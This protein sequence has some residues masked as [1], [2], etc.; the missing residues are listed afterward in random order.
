MYSKKKKILIIFSTCFAVIALVLGLTFGFMDFSSNSPEEATPPSFGATSP[1]V[2]TSGY[3]TDSGRY[4]TTAWSGSGSESDPYLIQSAQDLARLSYMVYSGSGSV[5]NTYYYYQ[6]KYFKQTAN[7]DLSAY[8][9]Q[10]IGCVY[11]QGTTTLNQ[12]YFSGNYDGGG[13]TVSGIFTKAG[14]T[15][16]YSYQ[17]LFGYIFGRSTSNPL[18]IKN[19]GVVNSYIQGHDYIGGIAG[20]I[21]T[22]KISNC[23]N[24]SNV[25]GASIIG[26]IV[27]TY[28]YSTITNCYNTGAL[29]A[30]F[31][32][33]GGMAGCSLHLVPGVTNTITN[34]Y[35]TGAI[36]A[37][38]N[39]YIGGIVGEECII[40]NCYYGGNCTLS[41]GAGNST[42]GTNTGTTKYTN[43]NSTSYAKNKSW[44]TNS[45]NWNDSYPW[46]FRFTW[47]I[48]SN[49]NS[50]YP[51]L[52]SSS[53]LTINLNGGSASYEGTNL[54][55]KIENEGSSSSLITSGGIR[56]YISNQNIYVS[57]NSNDD[58]DHYGHFTYINAYLVK[59]VNCNLSLKAVSRTSSVL[60][61]TVEAG[62]FLN[63]NYDTF[64]INFGPTVNSTSTPVTFSFDFTPTVSGV[65]NLR[66]D[67]N[68][69]NASFRIYDVKVKQQASNDYYG[70]AGQQI[71][72][73]NP[74]RTGYTFKGWSL[75]GGGSISNGVYTFGNLNETL[76]A[77]WEALDTE[78]PV[79]HRA[80]YVTREDGYD[81]YAYATDNIGV[82][83]MLFPTWTEYN[84]QDDLIWGQGIKGTYSVEGQTYNYKYAVNMSDHN[85]EIGVY[86][87]DIYAYD[88]AENEDKKSYSIYFARPWTDFAATSY[89]GGNGTESSPY[90]IATAQQLALL[91]KQ[92][93][94]ESLEGKY[95][96]QTAPIDLENKATKNSKYVWYIWEGIGTQA[97]P[98]QGHYDG[99]LYSISNMRTS[100]NEYNSGLFGRPWGSILKNIIL[101]DSKIVGEGDSGGVVGNGMGEMSNVIVENVSVQSKTDAAGCV[102]GTWR[103]T[104]TSCIAKDSTA[105]GVLYAGGVVAYCGA[106]M[107]DCSVLNVKV[108]NA[109]NTDI[110][111]IF[112]EDKSVMS[113]SYGYG[114]LKGT[115][116]KVMFGNSSSWGNWTYNS[117][118]NNGYPIQKSL[119]WIGGESGSSNVY[120][121]LKNTLGFSEG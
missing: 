118:I 111:A 55:D 39:Y 93:R 70:S 34:C 58:I 54:F 91:A 106:S 19:I 95:F 22:A 51:V 119:C 20:A 105:N 74:T 27:G 29:T 115:A 13:Y 41:Y 5:T 88:S 87:T 89:A 61:S 52:C 43:L 78:P 94:T 107:Y 110:L 77:T 40:K 17:G 46:D 9:W 15:D 30:V 83:K 67:T 75:S 23:Y 14:T 72:L 16:S 18:I 6:D 25:T 59:G 101:R 92:S 117:A 96:K 90:E 37:S 97:T 84:G 63:G 100:G 86:L 47:R 11:L 73:A 116:T 76:T 65:Y 53:K 102:A 81:V 108:E 7:I 36:S 21:Y 44:Y 71:T 42:G 45:S 104:I 57:S 103:G 109:S 35:N 32:S 82:V 98:F 50:G 80:T 24:T 2:N 38:G 28:E 12:H 113:G 112:V 48:N 4:G 60:N 79:I 121:Y 66:I 1:T 3:W 99:G 56:Y 120:N 26:G 62:M 114:T 64:Y 68:L 49:T 31:S 33:I 85:N 10:P 69:N 8:Y